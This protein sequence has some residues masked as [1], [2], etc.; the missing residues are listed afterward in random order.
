MTGKEEIIAQYEAIIGDCS[1]QLSALARKGLIIAILR[2]VVFAAAITMAIVVW[3][4]MAAVWLT[5]IAG[6]SLFLF[7]TTRSGAI[8]QT[9]DRITAKK[10]WA[11]SQIRRA[12]LVLDGLPGGSQYIDPTHHYS[13]D[14]D[15]FGDK[16]LFALLD[17]TS[18]QLGSRKL[19][20]W[21]SRPDT[22][23]D[24]VE[25]RQNA[26]RELTEKPE[27][28]L[29][30][31]AAGIIASDEIPEGNPE[32]K[33]PDFSI[34]KVQKAA[35]AVVPFLYVAAFCLLS[36]DLISGTQ[37]FFLF[38]WILLLGSLQ[39]KRIGKLHDWTDRTIAR[40]S[41]FSEV[42]QKIENEP[43]TSDILRMIQNDLTVSKQ[44]ASLA[45][46]RLARL[47]H[48]LDQRYNA[49]GYAIMNGFLLWDWRQIGNIDHWMKQNGQEIDRWKKAIAEIDALSAIASFARNNPDYTFPK[50]D[51]SGT[52]IM[53]AKAA[54]HPLIS[55]SLCVR[56]DIETI[57]N[58]S[59][60]VVTG[61]NMAGKSTYLRTVATNFLLAN[62]GAPVCAQ[63]MLFSKADLFT[64]LRTSDSLASGKSYFFA[65][66][67][68]LRDI[69]RQAES[70][71]RTFVILDEILRG[72]NSA[73][74]QKGSI[75]LVRK[76]IDLPV[77]GIIATH[78]LALGKLAE[79][80]PDKIRN[81]RFE[82]D[83][84]DSKQLS[85]SYRIL[86]GIAQNANASFLMEQMGIISHDIN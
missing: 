44:K 21:L 56:N 71:K 27:F 5:V 42:F 80:F 60:F 30:L 84:T 9:K 78:D 72:T 76:L 54:G 75:G 18:T 28:L 50:V 40:L 73:D 6:T 26:I 69:V 23:A 41:C 77:G 2:L 24:D 33:I 34:S 15:L 3:D 10:R 43:F 35:V 39:A 82:A 36:L 59:F 55:N 65:E 17:S 8:A 47:L 13:F 57:A 32:D 85:F 62:I 68:R 79:R 70:G 12:S 31:S 19:A 11:G 66:L 51:H 22:V 20:E 16:S 29:S 83:I 38:L 37:I 86:P 46:R 61:A 1:H 64:S 4:I 25:E 67:E 45:T 58:S 52:I 7:L 48:N 63:S 53:K 49:F 14:I 74:K 81:F